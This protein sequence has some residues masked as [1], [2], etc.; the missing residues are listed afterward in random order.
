MMFKTHITH[1]ECV[2]VL[3]GL[4]GGFLHAK[5]RHALFHF[6]NNLCTFFLHSQLFKKKNVK[7]MFTA[8][9]ITR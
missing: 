1:T 8:E 7:E 3:L 6:G 4:F 5:L 9:T 2:C